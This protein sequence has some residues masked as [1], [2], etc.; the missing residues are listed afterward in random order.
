MYNVFYSKLT[1]EDGHH[2]S[3]LSAVIKIFILSGAKESA[4]NIKF[5]VGKVNRKIY[6]YLLSFIYAHKLRHLCCE[7]TSE[8]QLLFTV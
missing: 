7:S 8:G 1:L 5:M 6:N 4:V 3:S 2:R